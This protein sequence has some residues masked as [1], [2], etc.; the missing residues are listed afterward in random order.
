M[1]E[2]A[3][4]AVEYGT[5]WLPPGTGPAPAVLVLGG[6]EGGTPDD[7]GAALAREGFLALASPCFGGAGLPAQLVEVPL[8]RFGER[9]RWL[10]A[11]PGTGPADAALPQTGAAGGPEVGEAGRLAALPRGPG[12]GR[13]GR[14]GGPIGGASRPVA[15]VGRSKGGELA[16][17]V[18]SAYPDL[19]AAVVAYSGSGVGW[20]GI[21]RGPGA[22]RRPARPSWTLGGAAVP[23]LPFARPTPGQVLSL[24]GYLVGRPPPSRPFYERALGDAAAVERATFPVERFRGPVLL[25]SGADDQVWPSRELAEIAV[26][27]LGGPSDAARPGRRRVEH[28]VYEGTGHLAGPCPLR[29]RGFAAGG[30]PEANAAAAADA[31]P[32]VVAFLQ[33]ALAVSAAPKP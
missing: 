32:R 24:L 28:L 12:A 20:Q 3:S 6:S 9:L 1:E 17:L 21:D 5:L 8:E 22:Y 7:V 10:A 25:V 16:L 27:R 18:A 13:Q 33:S 19:V 14:A 23:F 26:R 31:W 30:T 11:L 2:I 15:V 4:R 29:A